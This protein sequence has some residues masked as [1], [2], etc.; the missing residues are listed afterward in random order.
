MFKFR[1]WTQDISQAYLQS[2]EE[3]LRDVFIKPTSEF[4]QSRDEFLKLV[5]PL[6]GLSDAGDYWSE[7][8]ITHHRS[9]LDM[10]TTYGD[11]CLFFKRSAEHLAG[12]SGIFIDDLIRGGT[13]VFEK[14]SDKTSRKFDA[15]AK[16]FDSFKFC[17]I[18]ITSLAN[19]WF[20]LG[21][22]E[23]VAKLQPLPDPYNLSEFRSRRQQLGWT[24]HTRPDI[25][26]GLSF[27]AQV[28]NL[29]SEG[30][31]NLNSTLRYVQRSSNFALHI[32]PL[33]PN[34]LRIVAFADSSN[35]N[36][37]DQTSQLGYLVV[38]VDDCDACNII[39]YASY[40]SRRVIRSV[41]AGELHSFVDAFD[42][43]YLL[44]RYLELILGMDVPVQ[45]L[46]DSQSL[47]DTL[48]TASYTIGKRLMVDVSIAREALRQREIAD[49][50][51][52]PTERDPAD[53]F[54]KVKDCLA[55]RSILESNELDLSGSQCILRQSG[56]S[57]TA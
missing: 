37:S 47:F 26:C 7:T 29:S 17:G 40:K 22:S 16:E 48:T 8:I 30:I 18:T 52:I 24:V 54:T 23:Y 10:T 55:L 21:Q 9:D 11:V 19:S 13:K 42:Y 31:R 46:T 49:V 32:R 2:A 38:L 41:L 44:K 57:L 12:M 1:A 53:A 5:K 20:S 14:H 6:Y 25:A 50:G 39:H 28:V 43:A 3:L 35:A 51:H 27:L 4:E 33:D 15:H 45:V 56:R 36:N 34:T